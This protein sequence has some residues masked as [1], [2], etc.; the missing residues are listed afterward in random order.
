VGAAPEA[1]RLSPQAHRALVARLQESAAR[2]VPASE[3]QVRGRRW[4]RVAD[5]PATWW[6]GGSLLHGG[7]AERDVRAA[8]DE[9]EGFAAEQGASALVQVCPACPPG[10]DD[11]LDLR[12]YSWADVVR[13]QVADSR[14]VAARPVGAAL[15]LQ[16]RPAPDDAWCDLALTGARPRAE[17]ALLARVPGPSAYVTVE[18]E[19]EPVAVGRAFADDGWAGVFSLTTRP[20]A[21]RGGG[22]SAVLAA[23][24][25]WALDQGCDFLYLQ[26]EQDNEA[27]RTLFA[28]SGFSDLCSYHYRRASA[29]RRGVDSPAG[30]T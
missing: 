20:A 24:A 9:A 11:E 19:G 6:A 7:D 8:V 5:T 18:H 23:L 12:G 27:A 2:A 16:T 21:R 3:Q 25:D 14:V 29:A 10:L 13:L 22:G 15:N 4:L 28:A 1:V 17:R 26:V 30:P